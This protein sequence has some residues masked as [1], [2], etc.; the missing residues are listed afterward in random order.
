MLDEYSKRQ[1][2]AYNILKNEISNNTVA[3]AYLFHSNNQH[4]ATSF[5]FSF[6]KALIC[7]NGTSSNNKCED[8][9][10][11]KRIDNGNFPEL[12]VIEPD[13]LWIKK[14]QLIDLQE[15]FK[16]KPLEGNKRIYIIKEVDK[17][18]M[19]AAN[20]ILKFL[21]E[22]EQDIIALLTTNDIHNV[23]QTIISRCQ[24]IGLKEDNNSNE[25]EINSNSNATLIKIG[26]LYYKNKEDIDNFINDEKNV[27]RIDAV[28]DFV[29]KYETTKLDI[30]IETKKL[31]YDYFIDK[32]DY[33]WGLDIMAL[34]YKDAINL[35][36]NRKL[37]LFDNYID[38][39]EIVKSLNKKEDLIYKIQKILLIKEK[40][41][42]NINTN[43]LM[44]K[45]ILELE[46]E[47]YV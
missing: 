41:K 35:I 25:F 18:N 29:K 24:I 15:S 27:K 1:P 44:D 40:V 39:L 6:A 9:S 7:P 42:Y 43:L 33:I 8:C 34:F 3:H 22:P 13:G 32:N 11:C 23:L 46:S 26:K 21:E 14:E 45:L 31:W 19:Q 17:L 5:A 4:D 38:T 36:Y 10:I 37:E 12:K 47:E 2:V 16:T 20:S 28:V 30:L